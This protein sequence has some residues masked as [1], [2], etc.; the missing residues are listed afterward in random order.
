MSVGPLWGLRMFIALILGNLHWCYQNP[1]VLML[2]LEFVVLLPG[3]STFESSYEISLRL[4]RTLYDFYM[5]RTVVRF[6]GA[7]CS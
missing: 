3:N 6:E 7:M 5:S 2:P 4:R 1:G